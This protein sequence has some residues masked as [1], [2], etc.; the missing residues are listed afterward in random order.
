MADWEVKC[1][2]VAR[3]AGSCGGLVLANDAANLQT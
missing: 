1:F 3:E 2:N